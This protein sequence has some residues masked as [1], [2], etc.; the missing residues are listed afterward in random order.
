MEIPASIP[1]VGPPPLP[2]FEPLEFRGE[3]KEYFR[4]WIVNFF[5]TILTL[6][7]Y[8]PWARVR[9]RRYFYRNTR[10]A[11]HGFDYTAD[12]R[13]LLLG[14]LIVAAFMV[15]YFFGEWISIFLSLG[16]LFVFFALAPWIRWKSARFR[17]ANSSYRHL[18]LR[19][20]GSCGE[21]YRV[22]LGLPLLA[23]LTL[24]LLYPLAMFR[25]RQYYLENLRY[26]GAEPGFA[27]RRAYFF[28]VVLGI[29]GTAFVLGSVLMVAAFAAGTSM[30]SSSMTEERPVPAE[31]GQ[32]EA[33]GDFDPNPGPEAEEDDLP[34][35]LD[36]GAF[37]RVL[38]A[39]M[40]GFYALLGLAA[41]L[42]HALL[43]NHSWS[44]FT[45]TT[46]AGVV[47]FRCQLHPG[48]YLW[49]V[50]SNLALTILTLGV[51]MPFAKVRAHRYRISRMACCGASLLESEEGSV[52][53]SVGATGESAS[54]WL[55]VEFGL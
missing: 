46:R 53:E 33:G 49:I 41:V 16:A 15:A 9:T 47:S 7:F 32:L 11:G 26:G 34:D 25:Q 31:V 2:P 3:G 27:G 6:G 43:L 10:L 1:H 30:I 14:Y 24:G 42:I 50:A 5:L 48:R 13:K 38:L 45:L 23:M 55:D 52:A 19:F 12:P 36:T 18:R 28:A 44:R 17:A 37:E 8:T 54:D 4:I 29:G 22:F 20:S 51:F 39:A 21:A 40:G 35:P